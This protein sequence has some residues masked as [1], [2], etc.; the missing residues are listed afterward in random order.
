M[1][2]NDVYVYFIRILFKYFYMSQLGPIPLVSIHDTG[3][4]EEA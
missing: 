2:V 4:S 1:V 3:Q